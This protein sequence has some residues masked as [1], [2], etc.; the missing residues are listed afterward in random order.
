MEASKTKKDRLSSGGVKEPASAISFFN[1]LRQF[2]SAWQITNGGLKMSQTG[3]L[4]CDFD[5]I[6]CFSTEVSTWEDFTYHM[7]IVGAHRSQEVYQA[8]ET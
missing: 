1:I 3:L 8:W 7:D 2:L 6:N 5:A 4:L